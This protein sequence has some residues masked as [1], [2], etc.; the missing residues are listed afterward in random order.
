MGLTHCAVILASKRA[1]SVEM[2]KRLLAQ[3]KA[4]RKPGAAA[5]FDEIDTDL[6]AGPDT[7]IRERED[8]I[9]ATLSSNDMLAQTAGVLRSIPGIGP[10][11][12]TT[13]IAEMPGLGAIAGGRRALR[14]VMSKAA[15]VAAHHKPSL[16]ILAARLRKAGMPHK[17]IP[18]VVA[19]KRV[20]RANARCR[21]RQKR[22]PSAN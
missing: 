15:L 4:H 2:R 5:M 10:V 16:K 20:T 13:L 3:I 17:V 9:D 22:A 21:S 1:Q 19:R 11:S 18:T 6:K 7:R 8:R 14:P 12:S